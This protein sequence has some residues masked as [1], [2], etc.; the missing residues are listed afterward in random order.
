MNSIGNTHAEVWQRAIDVMKGDA[1]DESDTEEFFS[2][3][4]HIL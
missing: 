1:E 2:D 4:V 3:A